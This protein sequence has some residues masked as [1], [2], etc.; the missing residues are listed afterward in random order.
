M[1]AMQALIASGQ[2]VDLILL[3]MAGMSLY[4][5]VFRRSA[6]WSAREIACTML[7]GAFI[8]LALRAA[9]TGEPWTMT[10]FWLLLSF[11]AHLYDVLRKRA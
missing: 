2:I 3:F 11:P 9:L 4:L 7:P 6:G 10:A 1:A 8:L 5:I